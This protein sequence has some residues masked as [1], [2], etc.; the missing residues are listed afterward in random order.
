MPVTYSYAEVAFAG[1]SQMTDLTDKRA[2]A[3]LDRWPSYLTGSECPVSNAVIIVPSRNAPSS[4]S[5]TM[6]MSDHADE[7]CTELQRRGRW[8]LS[9]ILFVGFLL[10]VCG[11]AFGT[12]IVF[13]DRS[14]A[15]VC[16]P[17]RRSR[18]QEMTSDNADC[19]LSL[20]KRP[21][22]PKKT[23]VIDATFASSVADGD[24]PFPTGIRML[25]QRRPPLTSLGRAILHPFLETDTVKVIIELVAESHHPTFVEYS[26]RNAPVAVSSTTPDIKRWGSFATTAYGGSNRGGVAVPSAVDARRSSTYWLEQQLQ[27]KGIRVTELGPGGDSDAGFAFTDRATDG[28][29]DPRRGRIKATSRCSQAADRRT[30]EIGAVV[31]RSGRGGAGDRRVVEWPRIPRPGA[32]LPSTNA[33]G[34]IDYLSVLVGDDDDDVST[35]LLDALAWLRPATVDVLSV[36]CFQRDIKRGDKHSPDEHLLRCPSISGGADVVRLMKR[37]GFQL[38]VVTSLDAVFVRRLAPRQQQRRLLQQQHQ[39]HHQRLA[40]SRADGGFT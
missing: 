7:T 19:W 26:R 34:R 2:G 35:A 13:N 11:A 32:L 29:F 17:T 4:G 23:D 14:N 10:F 22:Q 1:L 38:H 5:T 36:P 31:D 37:R 12:N 3:T 30:N 9:A 6:E 25:F 28:D 16:R 18:R 21:R 40:S 15:S 8:T 27:W 39:Q 24:Q 33:T 20:D